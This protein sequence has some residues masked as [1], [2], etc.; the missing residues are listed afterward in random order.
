MG[1]NR[2]EIDD[3]DIDTQDHSDEDEDTD[4]EED[5]DESDQDDDSDSDEDEDDEDDDSDDEDDSD[6]DSPLPK[7]RKELN[8][9]VAKA[10]AKAMKTR[11]KNR[12]AAD[13]RVSEKGKDGKFTKGRPGKSDERVDSLEK[14]RQKQEALEEK[15]Q[16]GHDTGLAPDEV[17]LAY[18]F[19][20]RPTS[21][22]LKDP[23]FKAA[24]DAHRSTRRAK[25]NIPSGGG[26]RRAVPIASKDARKMS[27]SERRS[28]FQS[29][30]Q[31]ILE[32]KGRR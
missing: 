24:L 31:E 11:G 10:I 21:K 20:K 1:K 23:V 17:D 7:N 9:V 16:F 2:E 29:R 5:E 30:R 6:D 32:A 13:R 15:R 25:A 19:F 28:N 14:F 18:R 27:D 12:S 3:A 26:Q 8:S 4:D 22:A